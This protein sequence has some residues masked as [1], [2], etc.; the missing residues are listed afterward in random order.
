MF[1]ACAV[2]Q[3]LVGVALAAGRGRPALASVAVV[4]LACV[5][6]WAA[7]RTTGLP[8]V[9]ALAQPEAVGV[10][11]LTAA[12]MGLGAAAT[13]IVA[14]AFPL[15]ARPRARGPALPPLWVLAVVPTLIGMTAPHAHHQA[16]GLA[17]DPIFV[18][19][20]TSH[21]SEAQ[22]V[23]AKDVIQRTRDAAR[24]LRRVSRFW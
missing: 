2:A 24:R 12:L 20:D 5:G 9:D 10:P 21:A 22:L 7:S 17:A 6:A 4:N 23:A 14:F 19:A 1:A 8:V 15:V 3:V 16:A 13:A 11:D 18:G